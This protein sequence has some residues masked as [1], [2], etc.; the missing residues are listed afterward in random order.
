MTSFKNSANISSKFIL[1]IL[2]LASISRAQNYN[3]LSRPN[4]IPVGSSSSSSTKSNLWQSQRPPDMAKITDL[5]VM[6]GNSHMEVMI[7]FDRPFYGIVFSKGAVDI[8]NCI[9]VQPQS[10]QAAYKFKIMYDSCGSKPDLNGKFYENNIVIQYDKDLIEVWD[11]A[12]RLRCEWYND[13]EKGQGTMWIVGWR[14]SKG[15]GP[16]ASPVAGIVPLG[17]T[18]TMVVGIDD[19]QG[20]FDMRLKSCEASDSK[21]RPILLSDENGCVLRPKMISKF[22]KM[23]SS[24]SRATVVTYAFFHAFKFPDSMAVNIRCKSIVKILEVINHEREKSA[25][26]L[27]PISLKN[28]VA[29]VPIQIQSSAASSPDTYKVKLDTSINRPNR[30]TR[31]NAGKKHKK[32]TKRPHERQHNIPHKEQER[33][34]AP[35]QHFIS[36]SRKIIPE[37]NR[38]F[39]TSRVSLETAR[40]ADPK[41]SKQGNSFTNLFMKPFPVSLGVRPEPLDLPPSKRPSAV[42][43]QRTRKHGQ[44]LVFP[45]SFNTPSSQGIEPIEPLPGQSGRTFPYGPRSLNLE[46]IQVDLLDDIKG[47]DTEETAMLE[48]E[49]SEEEL[50]KQSH[51]S[52]IRRKKRSVSHSRTE[53]SAEL[54]VSS[55]Y[56]VISEVDLAFEAS[57]VVEDAGKVTTF[58][59]RMKGEEIVY[60]ICLPTTS[61]SAIFVLLAL[62]TVISVLVS[63]FV[64]YQRQLQKVAEESAPKPI[65]R[66]SSFR[67]IFKQSS[68]GAKPKRKHEVGIPPPAVF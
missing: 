46:A 66:R 55:A 35:N 15:R 2:L 29:P 53:R 32:N 57:D 20:E 8:Y 7:N 64:C 58:Q 54:G 43:V 62:L 56:E 45:S 14:F 61:F 18:L 47:E 42:P 49:P 26:I 40:T 12:K 67:T 34:A 41:S 38:H 16:W 1:R 44:P 30:Q 10:G 21:S 60:G 63:G 68:E 6:C 65:P 39:A 28:G 5:E 23:K 25:A 11:E 36:H 4:S 51:K 59:G 3:G 52:R 24:D 22:M 33:K 50:M 37:G 31:I 17:T 48:E 27:D 13:Y 19:K 9:Y